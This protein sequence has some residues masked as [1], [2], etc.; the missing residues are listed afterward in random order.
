M[1]ELF[2]GRILTFQAWKCFLGVLCLCTVAFGQG[3]RIWVLTAPSSIVEYDPATF[4]SKQTIPVPNEVLKS[5]RIFQVNH[6]GQ[7][8]FAPNSED[9]SPAVGRAGERPWFR[10]GH[11]AQMLGRETIRISSHAGSNQ[12]ASESAPWPFPSAAS[13]PLFCIR[14]SYNR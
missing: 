3:Q 14:K 11:A 8:L 12:K 7:M 1:L 6:Q 10:D 9:P 5:P 2:R 4:A 13:G